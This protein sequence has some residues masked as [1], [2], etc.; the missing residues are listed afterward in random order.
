MSLSQLEQP[1]GHRRRVCGGIAEAREQRGEVEAAVEP[2]AELGQL[3]RQVL[4]TDHMIGAMQSVLDVAENGVEPVELFQL[5]AGCTTAG[6]HRLVLDVGSSDA[7][8]AGKAIADDDAVG[9][10]ELGGPGG[11]LPLAKARHDVHTQG[12]GVARVALGQRAD[13]GRFVGRAA[14]GRLPVALP[15][16][17][18]VVDLDHAGQLPPGIAFQHGLQELVL[19]A[20]G[21]V[22]GDAELAHELHRGDTVLLLGEQVQGEKPR[23]QRQLAVGEHGVGGQRCLVATVLALQQVARADG[24]VALLMPAGG[25]HEPVRPAPVEQRVCALLLTAVGGEK[26]RQAHPLLKLHAVLGHGSPWVDT[27][28]V[29]APGGLRT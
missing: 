29:C 2:V 10:D 4:R 9:V 16:P 15:A 3:A 22:V 6:N 5:D 12:H 21:R 27:W 14:P 7:V 8:K 17:V 11:E 1:I 13:E 24:V 25:A 18:H 28:P 19:D 20:P 23:G 26:L